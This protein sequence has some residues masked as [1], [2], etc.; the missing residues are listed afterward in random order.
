[1]QTAITELEVHNVLEQAEHKENK[2]MNKGGSGHA[3]TSGRYTI[4]KGFGIHP[5]FPETPVPNLKAV[6][7]KD[8]HCPGLH[9]YTTL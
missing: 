9:A 3:L 4:Q 7:R 1:L 6:H 5:I 2:G 8:Q